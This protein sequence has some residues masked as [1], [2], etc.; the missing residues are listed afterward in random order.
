MRHYKHIIQT[1]WTFVIFSIF[2]SITYADHEDNYTSPSDDLTTYPVY[3]FDSE[4][5]YNYFIL[6]EAEREPGY[7][8]TDGANFFPVSAVPSADDPTIMDYTISDASHGGYTL[9]PAYESNLGFDFI[10]DYEIATN[11]NEPSDPYDSHDD[12]L[13]GPHEPYQT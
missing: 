12:G 5:L 13:A 1:V 4:D 9:N 3:Y 11:Y 7:Y 2:S 6:P 8:Y 10:G